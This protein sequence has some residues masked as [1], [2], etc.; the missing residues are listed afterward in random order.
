M[1]LT[2]DHVGIAVKNL[3]E[4]LRFWR[5]ALGMREA[6][7]EDVPTEGVVVAFLPAGESRVEL[8]EASR[9]DSPIAKFVE[10]RGEGIHHVTFQV[11][12]IQ[13]VLDRLRAAGVPL[14]DDAPR[15]GA[16]GT[17]VA[18]LHPRAAGGVLVELVEKPESARAR[19]V[20]PGEPVLL[21]L[22]DP[23]EKLWGI[24][25]ERDASGI[26]IEGF[27]LASFDSWTSQI[28][29]N[30]EG[31]VPSVLF[32]PMARVERVLL[33]RGTPAL[34]SLSDGFARRTG[35]SVLEVLG[36]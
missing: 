2:I 29:R 4:R 24:L 35:R 5:D 10:K 18:F 16:S 26:T 34:P 1:S 28:E 21:Y 7:R 30:E 19:G 9:P 12:A 14:L 8:L 6:G 22:R 31:I 23:H 33:D 17:K 36:R 3:E 32:V 13:P 11:E 15:P 27:D 25:R 20:T